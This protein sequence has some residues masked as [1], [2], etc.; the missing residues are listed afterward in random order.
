M[1]RKPL[2]GEIVTTPD[3]DG[4]VVSVQEYLDQSEAGSQEFEA[5]LRSRLGRDFAR[6]YFTAEV[7]VD[8]EVKDFECW[9]LDYDAERDPEEAPWRAP[10]GD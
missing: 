7:E 5:F 4:T 3:G 8:G 1:L 9:E 10:Q 2:V 6:Q